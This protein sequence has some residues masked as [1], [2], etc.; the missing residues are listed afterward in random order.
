MTESHALERGVSPLD[1]AHGLRLAG[2]LEAALQ[3]ACS[4]LEADP[5][6]IAAA[7][8]VARLLQDAQRKGSVAPTANALLD[9]FVRRGDLA[10][11]CLCAQLLHDAGGNRE[12]ALASVAQSFGAG[13]S[14]IGDASPTPP[15]F[16]TATDVSEP[17]FGEAI[18]RL[19]ADRGG[20]HASRAFSKPKT[21]RTRRRALCL[22]CRCSASW[23]RPCSS[24]C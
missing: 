22:A 16:P 8:L 4:I 1:R 19:A 15:P 12:A 17:A 18:G 24:S 9:R 21:C 13:S 5:D 10:S 11:A 7:Y 2:Q 23:R 3:F 14:R 6:D 20:S